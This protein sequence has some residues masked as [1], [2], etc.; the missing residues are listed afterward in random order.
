[1]IKLK[2]ITLSCMV[3]L[4]SCIKD[5]SKQE[6]KKSFENWKTSSKKS[7]ENYEGTIL[8]YQ[9]ENLKNV[10]DSISFEVFFDLR[11]SLSNNL[12]NKEDYYLLTI[13]EGEIV[14]TNF[15]YLVKT[16]KA[17]DA[18]CINLSKKKRH[19]EKMNLPM[20]KIENLIRTEYKE[21]EIFDNNLFIFTI[22]KADKYESIIGEIDLDAW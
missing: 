22:N 17:Y 19:I 8:D 6:I 3:M 7:I 21:K 14:T 1:M 20:N 4:I 10:L 13:E 15:Y 2:L 9:K 12:S 16:K 18:V 11:N 5:N